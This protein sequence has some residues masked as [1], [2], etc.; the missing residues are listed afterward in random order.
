MDVNKNPIKLEGEAILEVKTKKQRDTTHSY[1][2]KQKS[3]TTTGPRLARQIGNWI[4]GQ[5]ENQRHTTC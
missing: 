5:Q 2:R 1:H 3:S 4:A